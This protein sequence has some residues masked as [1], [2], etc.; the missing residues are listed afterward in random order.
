MLWVVSSLAVLFLNS[1]VRALPQ[2]TLEDLLQLGSVFDE[3]VPVTIQSTHHTEQA[4][5]LFPTEN[6]TSAL[7]SLTTHAKQLTTAI[8]GVTSHLHLTLTATATAISWPPKLTPETNGTTHTRVIATSASQSTTTST[9]YPSPSPAYSELSQGQTNDWRVIGIAVIAVSVVGIMILVIVFFDQWWGLLC[10][11]CG[12]RRKWL[13]R[14]KE[15]LVPDWER[16]SWE[17]KVEDDSLPAYP[18]FGAPSVLAQ[19]W[20]VDMDHRPDQN[21]SPDCIGFPPMRALKDND[22]VL[23]MQGMPYRPSRRY[24]NELPLSGVVNEV[25]A[26][27]LHSPLSRSETQRSTAP[28]DAYD[29]LAA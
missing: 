6:A 2:G 10:D 23:G 1:A 8:T 24:L 3:P 13:G 20:K 29:G 28:E 22:Q 21:T 15:E 9:W 14:G 5:T 25:T 12:R 18:S 7:P 26:C 11:V 4:S 17:F 19:S 27:K 16:G